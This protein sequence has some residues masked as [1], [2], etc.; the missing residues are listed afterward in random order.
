MSKRPNPR[1][2]LLT[3]NLFM[4]PPGIKNHLDDYKNERLDQIKDYIQDFDILCFQELFETGN[5]RKE[6]LID[7]GI[8]NSK[9]SSM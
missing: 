5:F 9:A 2:R 4:R 6:H 3:Y 8:Q 7:Y 1:V